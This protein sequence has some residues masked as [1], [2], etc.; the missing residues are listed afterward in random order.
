MKPKIMKGKVQKM[1]T[2]TNTKQIEKIVSMLY[3]DDHNSNYFICHFKDGRMNSLRTSVEEFDISQVKE[4]DC[5]ISL[6]GFAAHHRRQRECRQINGIVFDLDYHIPTTYE[7]L[8]WIKQ[9]NLQYILDAVHE[10]TLYEPN[11]ITDT[12]RGLQLIYL[13]E[14]SISYYCKGGEPNEK[15]LYACE[16][17]RETIE[18]QLTEILPK[19]HQLDI[20]RNVYDITRIVRLPGTVNSKTGKEAFLVHTNEDYYSFSDFYT[21]PESK[22]EAQISPPKYYA[23]YK[24]CSQSELQKLRM[25]ELEK[26]QQLRKEGCEG[27]RNYMTFIYYNS[28]VQIYDKDTAVSK[29]FEFADRFQT[30]NEPFTKAQVKAIIRKIDSNIT[31]AYRG[32]YMITKDWIMDKLAITDIE[33]GEL[34]IS[35]SVNSRTRKKR[36]NQIVKAERN[37]KIIEM[38]SSGVKHNDIAKVLGISRRTVQSV[39][40]NNGL[41]RKYAFNVNVQKSA[42]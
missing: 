3:H 8:E 36:A 12:S 17:I 4:K 24:R 15:A 35:K 41:T 16:R 14:N 33:A 18:N 30:C 20:D 32:Y 10:N 6:N 29:T 26:L 11:I 21:K 28:A 40:K 37:S 2:E 34:G 38:A 1:I 25:E 42:A 39:L 19:E 7:F 31:K 23:E 22:P 27:Y 13:F 9:H 5:Y